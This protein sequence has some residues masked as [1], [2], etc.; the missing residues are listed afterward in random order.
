[1]CDEQIQAEE[2]RVEDEKAIGAEGKHERRRQKRVDVG[3][4][5]KQP[6]ADGIAPLHPS[7]EWKLTGK[8]K[9]AALAAF[10]KDAFRSRELLP[11][12][13][14]ILPF[15]GKIEVTG[16]AVP[17]AVVGRFVAFE[18]LRVFREVD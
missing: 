16:Q 5:V 14:E 1:I 12:A 18:T 4:T 2:Q 8:A 6:A 11:H 13:D 7:R 10:Q 9:V 3:L 17:Q 15:E